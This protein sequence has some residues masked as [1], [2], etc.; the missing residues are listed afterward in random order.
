[1]I[2]SQS[3]QKNRGITVE[4]LG[5]LD[6]ASADVINSHL[7]DMQLAECS[8]IIENGVFVIW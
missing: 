7:A 3:L 4:R 1:M 5:F 8:E 2:I 6:L